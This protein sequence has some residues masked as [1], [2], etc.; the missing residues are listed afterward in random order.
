MPLTP[1]DL[2]QIR[3]IEE[4]KYRYLRF[5]DLKRWDDL[6]ELLAPDATASYGGGAYSFEG[7]DAIMGFL[8]RTMA[9]ERVL[10]SH[11]CHHPEISVSP[12]GKIAHGTWALDDVVVQQEYGVTIRG[13]A[14]YADVYRRTG[15]GWLIAAT[16]YQRV[17]EEVYPRGSLAGLRVTA[18]YWGTGGRST[19][20]AQ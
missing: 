2:V 15:D 8:R 6:A 1:D 18:D 7:R 17:Y 5:L 16:G 13:A 11:K 9:S 19:L 14:F 12:D 3:L 20:R 4:L 10:T